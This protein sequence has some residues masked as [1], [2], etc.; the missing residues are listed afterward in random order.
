MNRGF[1]HILDFYGCDAGQIEKE[2]FWNRVM[3]D[4]A[5][6]AHMDV[7]CAKFHRFQPHGLTGFLLLST[8]H[9]SVHTW[10]EHRHAACDLF[11][12]AAPEHARK[13]VEH[14]IS[15][16]AHENFTHQ[17]IERGFET[18]N[19]L[20]LPIYSTSAIQR[21]SVEKVLF[22]VESAFQ[23]IL[24]AQ[25]KGFGRCLLIDG[26]MQCA[27]ADHQLYDKALL[28]PMRRSD[29]RILI[30]GGGDGYVAQAA[31]NKAPDARMIVVDI[32]AAVVSAARTHLGQNVF[33]DPRVNLIIGDGLAYLESTKEAFDGIVLD[34]TDNPV[35]GG[36]A[37][38]RK[39]HNRLISA[40]ALKTCGWVSLQA[41]ASS[42][43]KPFVEV[44]SFLESELQKRFPSVKRTDCLIPSFGESNCFLHARRRAR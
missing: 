4:A 27:E 32:D 20:E 37:K 24:V 22:E 26:V 8:S 35:G 11:S 19:C 21:F 39:F 36:M 40:C 17:T 16:V 41:G 31:L 44:A 3:H 25:I 42:A 1:H 14:L 18:E 23:K 7:L 9:L 13:A 30:L 6:K 34:L 10:P 28:S 43:K 5:S 12:C 15:K 29:R 38:F 2:G 33:E